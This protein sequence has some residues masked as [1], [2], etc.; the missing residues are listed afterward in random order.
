MC[1]C[2]WILLKLGGFSAYS[3][4]KKG[5][6]VNS[7]LSFASRIHGIVFVHIGFETYVAHWR[8]CPC[9]TLFGRGWKNTV[10]GSGCPLNNT[11]CAICIIRNTLCTENKKYE[12]HSNGTYYFDN[13]KCLKHFDLSITMWMKK[14]WFQIRNFQKPKLKTNIKNL[15][16]KKLYDISKPIQCQNNCGSEQTLKYC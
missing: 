4:Q 1:T 9:Q 6:D 14:Y 11:K 2:L 7:R 16:L 8:A 10:R 15:T 12:T 13:V 3:I 5:M